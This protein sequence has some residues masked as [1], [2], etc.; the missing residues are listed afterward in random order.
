MVATVHY[1][2]N[3]HATCPRHVHFTEAA[4]GYFDM[5]GIPT[6]ELDGEWNKRDYLNNE[7]WGEQRVMGGFPVFER[8]PSIFVAFDHQAEAVQ[9]ILELAS[10]RDRI[11]S[12]GEYRVMVDMVVGEPLRK[13]CLG[14]IH[15]ERSVA[16]L[17]SGE[18][19]GISS[20]LLSRGHMGVGR[21]LNGGDPCLVGKDPRMEQSLYEVRFGNPNLGP[22][23]VGVVGLQTNP[24]FWQNYLKSSGGPTLVQHLVDFICAGPVHP[25]RGWDWG[26]FWGR[27]FGI[28]VRWGAPSCGSV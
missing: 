19:Q 12:M 8:H 7:A 28:G 14:I 5:C 9:I 22:L 11:P 23:H 18:L 2:G 13:I 17:S 24:I 27:L 1:G 10:L 4:E 6:R 3:P 26:P 20:A 16:D 25:P 21:Y 15:G